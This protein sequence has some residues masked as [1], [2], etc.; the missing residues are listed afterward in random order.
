[1]GELIW[2]GCQKRYEG[3]VRKWPDVQVFGV[4]ERRV[5]RGGRA[6]KRA[7]S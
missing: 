6:V 5:Q 1:M 3:L 7:A 2:H 4:L